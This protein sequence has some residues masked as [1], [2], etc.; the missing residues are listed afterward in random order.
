MV[1]LY[2]GKLSEKFE[3]HVTKE[4]NIAKGKRLPS[5]LSLQNVFV[6]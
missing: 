3:S 6:L 1:C 5:V 4:P 2:A